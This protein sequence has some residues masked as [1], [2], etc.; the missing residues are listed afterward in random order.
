MAIRIEVAWTLNQTRQKRSFGQGNLGEIFS[1]IGLG[2]LS[3]AG[4]RK[5]ST[6]PHGDVIGVELENLLFRKPLLQL[7]RNQHLG[8]FALELS[9]FVEKKSASHLHGDRGSP[10]GKST[11]TQLNT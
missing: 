8:K 7:H 6:L 5:G 11:P 3:Q 1:E 10:L 4:D 9:F 2:G